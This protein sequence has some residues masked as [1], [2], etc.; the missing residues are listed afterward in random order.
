MIRHPAEQNSEAWLY[1][2]AGIPT[3][4]E[5]GRILTDKF[6]TRTGEMP[7]TYLCEKLA[8]KWTGRPAPGFG[9][10]SADQGQI[11]EK[12]ALPWVELELNKSADRPGLLLTDDRRVGCSP[13]GLLPSDG[14]G[15]EIKC[16]EATQHVKTLV[17]GTVPDEHLCQI[18]GGMYVTGL[19]HWWFLSYRRGFPNVLLKVE[20]DDQIQEKIH[21]ALTSFL[22]G[23]DIAWDEMCATNGGPPPQRNYEPSPERVKFTWEMSDDIVP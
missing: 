8:E 15:I 13:D 20:R 11:L 22:A 6:S 2:R 21:G 9:S 14:G 18:H 23:F 19:R 16:P 12:E 3:A 1:A 4:S 10:W 7:F 17:R 5:F